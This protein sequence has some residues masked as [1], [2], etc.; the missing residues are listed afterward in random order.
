MID[1][2]VVHATHAESTELATRETRR[3]AAVLYE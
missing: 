3:D 1:K 2:E